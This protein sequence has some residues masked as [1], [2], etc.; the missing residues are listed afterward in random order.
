LLSYFVISVSFSYADIVVFH[1]FFAAALR[2][3]PMSLCF[4]DA[5]CLLLHAFLLFFF[6]FIYFD[7][8]FARS[9][10][11]PECAA[12]LMLEP[13]PAC[14]EARSQHSALRE[15]SAAPRWRVRRRGYA[16]PQAGKSALRRAFMRAFS[17]AVQRCSSSS[18]SYFSSS[19]II[20]SSLSFLLLLLS[21][22]LLHALP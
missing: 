13:A 19:F 1:I 4:S 22:F 14:A 18:S 6:F 7:V 2:L 11:L 5:S 17:H 12:C 15:G 20:S 21:S 9:A 3:L 16:S 8:V 10:S